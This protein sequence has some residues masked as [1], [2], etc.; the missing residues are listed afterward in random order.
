V[1]AESSQ[2]SER[3]ARGVPASVSTGGVEIAVWVRAG[4]EPAVLFAHATGFHGRCW[5]AVVR[6]LPNRCIAPDLRGHGHSSKPEPPYP[7]RAFGSDLS[8]VARELGVRDAIG[9]GHSMGGHSAVVAA[10]EQPETFRGLLLL[11]PT[12]FRAD[13]YGRPHGDSSFIARRRKTWQ[14]PAEMFERFRH[15]VPFLTWH[16]E[17]LRDYCEYGLLPEGGEYT[18]ACSPTI[19]ASIYRQSHAPEADLHAELAGVRAPVVVMRAGT[20]WKLGAF[21]LHS[22]PTAPDLASEFPNGR[23]VLL[24]GRTH[25]FPQESPELIAQA[26]ASYF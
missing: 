12:I 22:S 8:A 17:V 18:L 21:D 24:E 4:T 20:P 19:E 25:Y 16:P 15:R 26:I 10:L 7:W 3:V 1:S 2:P 6:R 13:Y 11:D 14:A 9:V 5:D 23:D